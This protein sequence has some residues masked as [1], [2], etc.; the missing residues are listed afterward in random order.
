MWDLLPLEGPEEQEKNGVFINKALS[1]QWN[2]AAFV[3]ADRVVES[4]LPG[5]QTWSLMVFFLGLAS[6]KQDQWYEPALNNVHIFRFLVWHTP[7][8]GYHGRLFDSHFSR[9]AFAPDKESKELAQKFKLPVHCWGRHS[10][11]RVATILRDNK[12][13]SDVA[14]GPCV[15]LEG[16]SGYG[17]RAMFSAGNLSPY[18]GQDDQSSLPDIARRF[19]AV[20]RP[21]PDL[22][23]RLPF[24][25]SYT[26]DDSPPGADLPE[27]IEM[28]YEELTHQ[29]EEQHGI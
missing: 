25:V 16:I 27:D 3:R 21:S 15:V 17:P 12:L 7:W 1:P 10:A 14:E 24:V 29:F 6:L 22:P 2:A 9:P 26:E 11:S 4:A 5:P 8:A 20:L 18:P 28:R 13:V 23:E 19:S